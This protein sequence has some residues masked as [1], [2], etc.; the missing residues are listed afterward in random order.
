MPRRS[1]ARAAQAGTA[2]ASA[3]EW[4]SL[5]DRCAGSA[6]THH[7]K[8]VCLSPDPTTSAM[9]EFFCFSIGG[10]PLGACSFRCEDGLQAVFIPFAAGAATHQIFEI[11]VHEL[12]TG[13]EDMVILGVQAASQMITAERLAAARTM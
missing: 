8:V 9:V 7:M 12:A 11:V 4:Q 2:S 6:D 3:Q 10:Q 5:L 13:G 1:N